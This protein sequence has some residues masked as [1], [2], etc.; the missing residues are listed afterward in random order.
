MEKGYKFRLYPTREQIHLITQTFG[1]C[2]Y[3]YNEALAARRKWYKAT[4]QVIDKYDLM[5]R[6]PALKDANPWL[7]DADAVALQASIEDMDSAYRCYLRG[8]RAGRNT[9]FPKYK[10]RKHDKASYR[11][12]QG[13]RVGD[14]AVW[15]PKVGWVKCKISTPV[16]GRVHRPA[17]VD[18]GRAAGPPGRSGAADPV[19]IS[20]LQGPVG[21]IRSLFTPQEN[22]L[23]GCVAF[24]PS[25]LPFRP[26]I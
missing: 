18:G 16:L 22:P 3:V 19:R 17:G 15:L 4:G 7:R 11:T 20:Q 5:R 12:K 25:L 26:A 24:P 14:K 1:C 10:T 2:R 21:P 13:T 23:L 6:L 8:L 9:G